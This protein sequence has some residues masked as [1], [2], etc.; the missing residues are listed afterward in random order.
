MG[1]SVEQCYKN[2]HDREVR[3]KNF[4]LIT[5]VIILNVHVG[6]SRYLTK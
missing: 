3:L 6:R 2:H 1:K 5:S 4:I